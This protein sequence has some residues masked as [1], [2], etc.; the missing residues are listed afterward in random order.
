MHP[1]AGHTR[2]LTGIACGL[3]ALMC[4]GL[5]AGAFLAQAPP[6]A[7][8]LIIPICVTLPMLAM[9]QA[10]VTVASPLTQLRRDLERLPETHHPLGL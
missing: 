1:D 3:T 5:L 7:L 8:V 9:W 4:A 6:A 10:T 2:L